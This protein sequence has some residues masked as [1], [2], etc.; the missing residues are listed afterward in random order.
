MSERAIIL[1][2]YLFVGE[3]KGSVLF[4]YF[5]IIIGSVL[6][7]L[8]CA[9][10]FSENCQKIRVKYFEWRIVLSWYPKVRKN[11]EAKKIRD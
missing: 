7:C 5:S 10:H 9:S 4:C 11:S 6:Y 8:N 1:S 2:N 3:G